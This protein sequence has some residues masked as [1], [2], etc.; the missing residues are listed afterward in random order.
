[1]LCTSS[2]PEGEVP[3]QS[4]NVPLILVAL[5]L[6]AC[7]G[8]S[9]PAVK[10][11]PKFEAPKTEAVPAAT[12]PAPIAAPAPKVEPE[13]EAVVELAPEEP[14]ARVM[15]EEDGACRVALNRLEMASDI[16]KREPVLL[17]ESAIANG[18]GIYAFTDFRNVGEGEEKVQVEWTH[19]AT[20]HF[21]AYEVEV[22]KHTRYRT[23][24]RHRIPASREGTWKVRVKDA[25][26][27][28]VGETTFE[29]E[30]EDFTHDH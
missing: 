27:C 15:P 23:W 11:K 13:P 2:H 9:P 3:M 30:P 5:A 14:K 17:G 10:S 16:A 20:A 19:P 24:T 7:D 6:G 25:D 8:A 12:L 4:I 26:G 22:G 28:V 1:L 21:F 18:E 29:A